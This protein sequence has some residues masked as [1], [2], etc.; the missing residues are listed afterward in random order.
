MAKENAK[1]KIGN[2]RIRGGRVITPLEERFTDL[3]L[4]DGKILGLADTFATLQG[5]SKDAAGLEQSSFV[6]FDATGLYVT[7]GL[8]DLQM[9]GGPGCDLWQDPSESDLNNMRQDLASHGVTSFLPT[10]IT[11]D[12]VHMRKNIDFLTAQGAS[13]EPHMD[14]AGDKNST[15]M[16]RMLGLHLEGPCLSPQRPGV[17]PPQHIQPFTVDVLK[18]IVTPAVSLMTAACEG[19]SDGVAIA[20]LR[21]NGVTA[22]LGHS[23]ATLEE[24]NAAFDR[25]VTLMTHTFNALPPLHHRNPGA[26]GAALLRDDVVCCLIADGLHLSPQ[27]CALILKMKTAQRAVLVTD[28]ASV[29]TTQ[30]GLV[31]SSITLEQAVQNICRWGLA[32]FTQAIAMA[33]INAARA[34]GLGEKIGAIK[35]G[36]PADLAF[37]NIEN[38]ELVAAMV[39]GRQAVV[40]AAPASNRDN[41]GS[42]SNAKADGK[43][44]TSKAASH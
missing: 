34:V 20:Y 1:E 39:G 16:A 29:G 42:K 19:D 14:A 33:T 6:D 41:G 9:N 37:F 32:D 40:E 21:E 25:G 24:A 35:P 17:H 13:R 22:S 3:W 8:I 7:P 31:G 15:A 23:N 28:R 44:K 36:L 12:L 38:L 26:V 5:Q 11:D 4:K 27:A 18:R 10:L 2:L 30:G 43:A